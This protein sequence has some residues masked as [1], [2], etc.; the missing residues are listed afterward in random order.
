MALEKSIAFLKKLA[1]NNNRDWFEK[2][3]AHYLEAKAEFELFI[4]ELISGIRKFDKRIVADLK[5]KDCV[6]RIYKDVRFSNDKSP[7]KTNFGASINP[8]GR[9]SGLPG[10]YFHVQPGELFLAGGIYRPFPEIVY[11][12][13]QEIDYEGKQLE[14]ILKSKEYCS[15]FNGLYQDDKLKT[16]PKGY[17]AEHKYLELLKLKSFIAIHEFS[18]KETASKTFEQQV[19]KGFKAAYPLNLYLQAAFEKSTSP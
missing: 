3:K 17:D 19:M 4:D 16:V 12:V 15:Y 7:Y 14:R 11:A 2:N 9:K 10:Y 13:R 1:K 8:G 18:E 6:F 5:A